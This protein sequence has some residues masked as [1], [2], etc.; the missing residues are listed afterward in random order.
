VRLL[1]TLILLFSITPGMSEVVETAVHVLA[2]RDLPHHD[3]DRDL[4]GS[5]HACTPLAHHCSCHS[6]MSAQAV[7]RTATP[8][9]FIH[10]TR[11]DLTSVRSWSGRASEPPPVRPPIG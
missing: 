7:S 11:P 4:P 10:I 9:R 5:E 2:H 6:P 8:Q 1:V 3:A